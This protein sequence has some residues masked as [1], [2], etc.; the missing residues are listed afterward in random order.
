MKRTNI[1]LVILMVFLVQGSA[2]SLTDTSRFKYHGYFYKN[3]NLEYKELKEIREFAN[4]LVFS[5]MRFDS[6]TTEMIRN[7]ADGNIDK[8]A[9]SVFD[10][11][12]R[13]IELLESLDYVTV[14]EAPFYPLIRFDKFDN[15][16]RTLRTL[17]ER[18]PWIDSL[19]VFSRFFRRFW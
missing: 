11:M 19:D 1:F 9:P 14:A 6:L 2:Q 13:R 3:E 4:M 5:M 15:Y 17:K 8:F 10:E 7:I 12:N 18:V 16:K